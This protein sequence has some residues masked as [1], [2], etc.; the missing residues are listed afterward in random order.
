MTARSCG[1]GTVRLVQG[2]ITRA[3][4]DAI[5]NAANA[6][7]AGGGGVDGAI[8]RAGGPS[9]MEECRRA[10]GCPT[11]DAV[12][13]TAGDLAARWVV[14]AVGPVY[15]GGLHDEPRLLASAYRRGLEVADGLGAAT[16]A[17]PAISAGV[18][19]YPLDEAAAIAVGSALLFL[20]GGPAHVR[21][22]TFYLF[23]ARTLAAFE[24]ALGAAG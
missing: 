13:T 1:P 10:G 24:R 17:C 19:G 6:R 4:A 18:Y 16:V 20:G 21:E 23:D 3:A 8:H 5:V 14:H 7:L 12:A 11:G 9:I 15:R 22:V 2:D